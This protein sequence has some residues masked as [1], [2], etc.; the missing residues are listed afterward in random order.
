VAYR[1]RII[2]GAVIIALTLILLV[3][4]QFFGLKYYLDA[5]NLINSL[6]K[7]SKEIAVGDFYGSSDNQI[8]YGGI[9][10]HI[11]TNNN[12]IRGLWVWGKSGLKYIK[13]NTQSTFSSFSI[14]AGG[15]WQDD[16]QII[17]KKVNVG[18]EEWNTNSKQGHFIKIFIDSGMIKEAVDYDWWAFAPAGREY[19]EKTCSSQ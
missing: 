19:L 3:L 4:Y 12:T 14:C 7:E 17:T 10:A 9:L 13:A 2:A 8:N 1:S 15:H 5:I 18:L 16:D 6:P 11:D